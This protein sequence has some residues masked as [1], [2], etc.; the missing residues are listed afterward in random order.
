MPIYLDNQATTPMDLRVFE[1]MAFSF[2]NGFG[3]PGS[4]SH[5]FGEDAAKVVE[6]S[7]QTIAQVIGARSPAEVIF[8][9]GATESNNLALQGI[10]KALAKQGKRHVITS[11]IEHKSVLDVLA[12]L[13]AQKLIEVSY[14]FPDQEGC[15][16]TDA[17]EQAIRPDTGLLS[18]MFVNNE[19]GII[20]PIKSIGA[21][22]KQRGLVF[23]CDA[24]QAAGKV[25]I[26]VADLNIDLLSISAHKIY[27]PKGSGALYV[28]N[29][30]QVEPII[31]GGGQERG[32]RSGTLPVPLIVGLAKALEI[33]DQEMHKDTA[34]IGGLRDQLLKGLLEEIPNVVINGSMD[35]RIY[36]N[37]NVSFLDVRSDTLMMNLWNDIAVSSGSACTSVNWDGS[38]VLKAMGFPPERV[39]SAIRFGLGR[40]TTKEEINIAINIISDT[41][42]RLTKEV[43]I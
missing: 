38:Y 30:C 37:L 25:P 13:E 5:R 4:H 18:F 22:A 43:I 7:R 16:N 34:R 40:F 39:N 29:S 20:N 26:N 23:H 14:L 9:S 28:R 8:T 19:I 12:N 41:H 11:S 17:I 6:K 2:M 15:F 24:A 27:G 42:K 3:N 10:L 21:L 35:K 36:N 1:A 33:A 32:L 31:F